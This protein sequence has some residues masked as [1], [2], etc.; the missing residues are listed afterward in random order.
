M[1]NL[2]AASASVVENGDVLR[3]HPEPVEVI[4]HVHFGRLGLDG[5]RLT[6]LDSR[7]LQ[8]RRRM[9]F[10]GF[11]FVVVVLDGDNRVVLPPRVVVRGLLEEADEAEGEALIGEAA[12][13]AEQALTDVSPGRRGDD[14][15]IFD[16]VSQAVRRVLRKASDGRRPAVEVE[17]MR[18]PAA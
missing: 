14:Q 9:M 16:R 12:R 10:N 4:D 17:V 2:P 3:L 1:L 7:S 11:A 13:A 8:A 15:L 18:L 6:A 5:G